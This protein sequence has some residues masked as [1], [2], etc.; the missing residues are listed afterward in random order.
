MQHEVTVTLKLVQVYVVDKEGNPVMDLE[1][2]D[3]VLYDKGKPQTITEFE[4]H[5]L[6]VPSLKVEPQKKEAEPFSPPERMS[7]KFFLFFD[8]AYNNA[9]GIKKSREA[10]LHFIDTQLQPSDE[11]GIL[12][13]SA[14]KSLT[15]HEYLTTNHHKIREVVE[16]FTPQKITG[17]AE[18]FEADY[19]SEVTGVQSIDASKAGKNIRR[20]APQSTPSVE[21]FRPREDSYQAINFTLKIKELAKALRYIPGYKHIILFSSGIPS[22]LIYGIQFRYSGRFEDSFL[23]KNYMEMLK[24]LTSA[25]STMYVLDSQELRTLISKD[26]RITG[27]YALQRLAKETGGK[28]FSN[29]NNYE[30][31]L[32]TVQNLTGSFYVLGYYI[33]E[34][35]D[36]RYHKIKVKVNRPKCK[37]YAQ[38]GYYNPKPFSKYSDLEKMFHLIDLALAE[39][40]VFQTPLPF[41]LTALPCSIEEEPNLC[42]I[43]K[44]PLEKIKEISGKKVE[45]F[46]LIFDTKEDIV[47]LKRGEENFTG[48]PGES[49][50][51]YSLFSLSPGTYKCRIV[52]R[53]L[54]TGQGAVGSSSVI[55]PERPVR[56]IRLSPPLLLVHEKNALY[57]KGYVP[58]KNGKDEYFSL[59]DYFHFDSTQ[60]SP[61]L[62]DSLQANA[63]VPAVVLY[64]T[65]DILIPEVNI[66]AHLIEA[67]SGEIIPL[68][69]TILSEI[70]EKNLDMR[71]INIQIPELPSGEYALS[72]IARETVSQ[73]ESQV[74][75]IFT[76]K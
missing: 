3:F 54:E 70:K 16:K 10:A 75:R 55:I 22:S 48:L 44:I 68:T 39:N 41:P 11:V 69:I 26:E 32:E 64:S 23:R 53:D 61:F 46:T 13:Y 9:I 63:T 47:N 62:G 65:A 14:L 17:R 34:K 29:L 35:W 1:K 30:K 59:A 19:W 8:F 42:L 72:L 15:L 66:S 12:S 49:I 24:E 73:S 43:A 74:T 40:P 28:Y 52:I 18:D 57:V 58:E 4:K 33:D 2:S 7:R 5:I 38:G 60:Y 20:P 37:V 51:L 45:I 31:D 6:T 27:R 67:S 21:P 25:N 56:G 50:Y 76:I 71:F 36:G